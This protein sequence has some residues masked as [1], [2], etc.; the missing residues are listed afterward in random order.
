MSITLILGPMFA[1]KT[2]ELMRLVKR[3]WFASQACC[4]VKY[5]MDVRYDDSNVATH[6]KQA[7]NA[8]FALAKLADLHEEWK[9]FDVI[10]IDEGQFFPDLVEFAGVAADAGKKVF[11]SALDGDFQR[12][13]FGKVCELIPQCEQVHKLTAVC[14]QC[15]RNEA[16]FTKRV[17]SATQT[18]LIGGDETYAAV[19][20]ACYNSPM[21]P[22]P[23]K[24]ARYERAKAL[25]T[26]QVAKK[27]RALPDGASAIADMAEPVAKKHAPEAEP[28]H[29]R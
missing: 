23:G 16:H 2:T 21:P 12:R 6:D 26:A 3:E 10:A 20:R 13:P 4:I 17:T 1:G 27:E 29:S 19:C 22:T 9:K 18:E 8:T 11:I 15:N 24:K 7:L 5:K 14:M 28:E 25:T